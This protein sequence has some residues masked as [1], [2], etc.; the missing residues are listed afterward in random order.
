MGD[1]G[2][3]ER[4]ESFKSAEERAGPVIPSASNGS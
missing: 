3:M 4:E 2:I 1:G